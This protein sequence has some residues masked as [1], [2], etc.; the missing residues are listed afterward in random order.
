M[1][2]LRWSL[3][4]H[5]YSLTCIILKTSRNCYKFER[6]WESKLNFNF[7]GTVGGNNSYPTAYAMSED[8][9][10]VYAF[11]RN[12]NK[13]SIYTNNTLQIN[14]DIPSDFTFNSVDGMEI[15][16]GDNANTL[17]LYFYNSN[18]DENQLTSIYNTI[19]GGK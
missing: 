14:F 3:S 18:L 9:T 6:T 19:Y 12:G 5:F 13:L 10:V 16:I 1:V 17:D 2:L 11:V 7:Y 4:L 8:D 15:I